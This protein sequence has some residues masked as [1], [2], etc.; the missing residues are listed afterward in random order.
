MLV[1]DELI[2]YLEDLSY[3][4]LSTDEKSRITGEMQEMLNCIAALAELNTEGVAE[5]SNPLDNVNVFRDDQVRPS[6]DREL[7]LLNAPVKNKEMFIAP[8][9]VD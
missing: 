4:R 7:I 5:C 6:F 3:L 2:E 1:N 8:K 9:T